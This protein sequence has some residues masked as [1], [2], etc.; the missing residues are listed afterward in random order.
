MPINSSNL[1]LTTLVWCEPL[2]QERR[3]RLWRIDQG[4]QYASRLSRQ[5]LWRYRMHQSMSRRGNCW[6]NAPMERV[7]RSLKTE[8]IPTVGYMTIQK[9]HRH[10]SHYLMHRNNWIRPHQFNGRLAPAQAEEKLNIVP[11]IS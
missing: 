1:S 5:R 10:I 9:A 8:W 3:D 2:R 11:G 4:S 6:D 7:F